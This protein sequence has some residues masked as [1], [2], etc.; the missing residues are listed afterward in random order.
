MS[1]DVFDEMQS[2][3][4]LPTILRHVCCSLCGG[5]HKLSFS[6]MQIALD[7]KRFICSECQKDVDLKRKSET[8]ERRRRASG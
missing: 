8:T 7:R 1:D 5:Q 6:E 3:L 4:D 2:D